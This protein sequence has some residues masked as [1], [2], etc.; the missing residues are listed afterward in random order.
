MALK[1]D[2]WQA[3]DAGDDA[4]AELLSA[5]ARTLADDLKKVGKQ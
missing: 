3:I 4:R 2:Y 1:I 5:E